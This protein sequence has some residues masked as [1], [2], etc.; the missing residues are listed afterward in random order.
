MRASVLRKKCGK[1]HKL[2]PLSAFKRNTSCKMQRAGTC[3]RCINEARLLSG[4][5][6]TQAQ[7][8]TR[9]NT[10]LR[11]RNE[12]HVFVWRCLMRMECAHCGER[13]PAVLAFHHREPGSKARSVSYLAK[14]GGSIEALLL[15]MSKCDVLCANCHAREHNVRLLS[16]PSEHRDEQ[17]RDYAASTLLDAMSDVLRSFPEDWY[18]R[19][20]NGGGRMAHALPPR[21]ATCSDCG[22]IVLARHVRCQ[23]CTLKRLRRVVRG[24]DRGL[25]GPAQKHQRCARVS[26]GEIRNQGG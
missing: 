17:Q 7:A 1:C 3:K 21:M 15:E 18:Y 19:A 12:R 4:R 8:A 10:A 9:R 22:C 13:D 24:V 6:C 14:N 23:S 11:R 2:L 20:H 25:P 5:K 16:I 26:V